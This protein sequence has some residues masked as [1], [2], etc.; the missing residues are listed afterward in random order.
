MRVIGGEKKGRRL[1]SFK[2]RGIR[3]TT[4]RIREAIFDTLSSKDFLFLDSKAVL[5]LFAGTGAL[6]IEAMSR[7]VERGIFVDID[8]RALKV[9]ERNLALCDLTKR[10]E[11]FHADV[12]FTLSRLR[13]KGM[14]FDLIFADPPYERGLAMRTIAM[15]AKKG[16][17]ASDGWMVVEHSRREP[18]DEEVSGLRCVDDKIYGDT[19]V[20]YYR[21]EG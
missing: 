9:I 7:G 2:G 4:D 17:L 16:L 10:S 3:P 6:G 5:D 1:G 12:F 8:G 15:V 13:R 19:V 11:L 14:V 21:C 20:S 18:V